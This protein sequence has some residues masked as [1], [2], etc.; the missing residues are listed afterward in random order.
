MKAAD[1]HSF[2]LKRKIFCLKRKI[3]AWDDDFLASL[4]A[5]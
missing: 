4:I 3:A 2:C 1:K 5:A